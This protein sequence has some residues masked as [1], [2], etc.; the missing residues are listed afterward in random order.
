MSNYN[1]GYFAGFDGGDLYGG[2]DVNGGGMH[3]EGG[4]SSYFGGADEVIQNV[5]DT[6]KKVSNSLGPWVWWLIKIVAVVIV[7]FVLLHLF[8]F[9]LSGDYKFYSDSS[10]AAMAEKIQT[11]AH[12]RDDAYLLT[13]EH[14]FST[15]AYNRDMQRAKYK[16]AKFA[17]TDAR[18]HPDRYLDSYRYDMAEF[19]YIMADNALVRSSQH[20]QKITELVNALLAVDAAMKITPDKANYYSKP[21]PMEEKMRCSAGDV[22][23]SVESFASPSEAGRLLS[24]AQFFSYSDANTEARNLAM[25]SENYTQPKRNSRFSHRKETLTDDN[26]NSVRSWSD[27]IRHQGIDDSVRNS[28]AEYIGNNPTNVPRNAALTVMDSV[29]ET[30]PQ[31][32]FRRHNY[33]VEIDPS[34]R[35][36]PSE[37]KDQVH[38]ADRRIMKFM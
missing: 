30:V 16:F 4:G 31:L 23:S 21:S 2:M 3:E 35:S 13:R 38:V 36:V 15:R 6:V 32:G 33:E 25:I 7:L 34:S 24:D 22:I 27:Y 26:S 14:Y 10:L 37:Y 20:L 5:Q 9:F 19:R 18:S 29:V 12:T 1:G 28:H 8:M 11:G 17:K